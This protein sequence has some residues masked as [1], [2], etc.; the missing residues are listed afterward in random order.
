MKNFEKCFMDYQYI[1]KIFH[2]LHKNPPAPT[3]T[4]LMYIPLVDPN[5]FQD[6]LQLRK[7][8]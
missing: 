7:S 5:E 3:P 1:S 6:S 8:I 4:Y 2:D